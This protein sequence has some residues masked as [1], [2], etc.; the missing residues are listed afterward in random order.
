M[1]TATLGVGTAS[2]SNSANY[3]SGSFTP[4]AG[5]LLVV[6][7]VATATAADGSMT[8][9]GTDLGWSI[10]RTETKAA[11]A[12][13]LWMFV[14]DT[15]VPASAATTVTFSC[16]GD[17][18]TGA[19]VTVVRVA[20]MQRSGLSAI[21]QVDGLSDQASA[22][23][24]LSFASSVLTENPTLGFIAEATN[25]AGLTPPTGWT[26]LSDTGFNTP[27]TGSEVVSRDSGFTGTTITWGNTTGSVWGG[28]IAE[29]D[30][31]AQPITV[32]GSPT[33]DDVAASGAGSPVADA[34]GAVAL[35]DVAI[36]ASGTQPVSTVGATAAITLD[37]VAASG[38]GTLIAEASGAVAFA[39]AAVSAAARQVHLA[40]GAT[41]LD[42]VSASAV[43]T[44]TEQ[45]S[46][47]VSLDSATVAAAGAP[48]A[49]T[50]EASGALALGAV[51]AQASG[52]PIDAATA[53][54]VLDGVTV[55]AASFPTL[56]S[57]AAITL[58]GATVSAAGF[59]II[60]ASGSSALDDVAAASTATPIVV[61]VAGVALGDVAIEGAGYQATGSI[62][63]GTIALGDAVTAAAATP[64]AIGTIGATLGDVVV[65]SAVSLSAQS[66]GAVTLASVS[67]TSTASPVEAA[68]ASIALDA[69]AAIGVVVFPPPYAA[70]SIAL[71]AVGTS[72]SGNQSVFGT[73]A[74]GLGAARSDGV[75]Y[76]PQP[77]KRR[78]SGRPLLVSVSTQFR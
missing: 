52:T 40:T 43:A 7:V 38:A 53:A 27:T 5:D 65:F 66:V 33:L 68:G 11:S 42:A 55:E 13:K 18:A 77:S 20:G 25:P 36:A 21:L 78:R 35:G 23:P 76:Q 10:A 57:S 17:N 34:S 41:T 58:G 15:L 74:I 62:G 71:D 16:T 54:I 4:A 69:V 51:L 8:N 6:F 47:A 56:S 50:I 61:G 75:A 12:D 32:T 45:A 49:A 2:T 46:G 26:E 31:S 14:A 24:S 67:M 1:A 29:L 30:T 64:I 3:T 9:S 39:D 48:T 60:R 28:I 22:V 19:V 63:T 72:A 73:S 70:A 37:D 59:P 44:L